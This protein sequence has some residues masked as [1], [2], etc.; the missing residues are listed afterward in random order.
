MFRLPTT[1]EG[2]MPVTISRAR[3]RRQ[4]STSAFVDQDARKLT[5]ADIMLLVAA[6]AI[7]LAFT[8]SL[9]HLPPGSLHQVALASP[10]LAAWSVA[11]LVLRLRQPRPRLS[12]LVKQ[13][14]AI[15]CGLAT[16]LVLTGGGILLVTA[17]SGA[18][19]RGSRVGW[20]GTYWAPWW[21][22]PMHRLSIT[23]GAAIVGA[24]VSEALG[25]RRRPEASWIDRFGRVL[26][27]G[28]VL[29]FLVASWGDL[30]RWYW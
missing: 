6:T 25:R 28:W 13:P 30:H 14:G 10:V 8:R 3:S 2:L 26:G 23:I 5:L 17:A 15:A 7:G 12:R 4:S 29:Y 27:A 22:G 9:G 21:A 24:W 20:G 16:L 11:M 19:P 1:R 18:A